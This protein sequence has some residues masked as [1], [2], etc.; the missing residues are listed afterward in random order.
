MAER[1]E[2]RV[3]KKMRSL[4]DEIIGS[5]D[6]FCER[7]LNGEYAAVCR[8]LAAA[9]ARKRPSPLL[10]GRPRTWAAG[11]VY[12]AGSI[13][14]LFDP[15]QDPHMSAK[16]LAR[17]IGVSNSTM[18][19]K[20]NI[21]TEA[22]DVCQLHPEYTLPSLI[23]DNPHI[24]MLEVDGFVMD[25]RDAPRELQEAAYDQGLIPYIPGDLDEEQGWLDEPDEGPTIIPFPGHD[26]TPPNN[27]RT[28]T[29]ND[30]EPTLFQNRDQ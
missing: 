1:N 24:W 21:V 3:P 22:L 10:R 14:F 13:N 15:D 18:S 17:K 2:F 19:A 23:A 5:T 4:F 6:A 20:R 11:I 28:N 12:T 7:F 9:L 27:K 25:M 29:P 30:E 8:K 26:H 16:E